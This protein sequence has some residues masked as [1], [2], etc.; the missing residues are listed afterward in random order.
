[1]EA[2]FPGSVLRKLAGRENENEGVAVPG[3]AWRCSNRK[4]RVEK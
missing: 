4:Q 2:G 3:A 1:M